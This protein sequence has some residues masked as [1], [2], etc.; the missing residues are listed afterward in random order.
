MLESEIIKT[1]FLLLEHYCFRFKSCQVFAF[2]LEWYETPAD[3][4]KPND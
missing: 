2:M 4:V 3:V 1:L